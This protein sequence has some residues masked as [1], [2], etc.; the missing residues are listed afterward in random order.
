MS[1]GLA[2][3]F[4]SCQARGGKQ[5]AQPSAAGESQAKISF[6]KLPV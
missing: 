4:A 1:D 2:D 6:N 3:A 5:R